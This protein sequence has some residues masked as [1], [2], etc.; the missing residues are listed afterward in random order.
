MTADSVPFRIPTG[1]ELASMSPEA[2]NRVFERMK[3]RKLPIDERH[4]YYD[5]VR[6]CLRLHAENLL[7]L[8]DEA[9]RRF[10]ELFNQ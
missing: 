4:E 6:D 1:A 10:H 8:A 2:L 3:A 5:S 7:P 9:K